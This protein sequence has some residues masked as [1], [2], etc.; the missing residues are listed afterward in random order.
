MEHFNRRSITRKRRAKKSAKR[1]TRKA[2][3]PKKRGQWK[4]V[5]RTE[6]AR[7]LSKARSIRAASGVLRKETLQKN[8]V[9]FALE[10]LT[11]G[12]VKRFYYTE[13]GTF[14]TDRE[15]AKRFRSKQAAYAEGRRILGRLPYQ[16]RA[17]KVTVV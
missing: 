6:R 9:R 7:G 12:K 15:I 16:I 13:R 4:H 1:F 17:L 8:P 2:T 11:T 5:Y 10:G 3:T 14:D